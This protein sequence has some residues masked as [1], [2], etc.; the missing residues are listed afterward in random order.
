MLFE[1]SGDLLQRHPT[2]VVG[3]VFVQNAT[4]P[5]PENVGKLQ[6][7]LQEEVQTVPWKLGG[8]GL[9]GHSAI[10]RWEQ[11]FE[12][13]G[14]NPRTYVPS[15]AALAQRCL[16][17][18]YIRSIN[19]AADIANLIS[20][21]HLVPVGAHDVDRLPGDITVRL[22]REG[23]AFTASTADEKELP[24]GEPVYATGDDIRTRRWVWRQ[25]ETAM[26][27]PES[28]TIVFPV[29]GFMDATADRVE[30]ATRELALLAKAT[31]GGDVS[32]GYV[33]ADKPSLSGDDVSL[34]QVDD[35]EAA[36]APLLS[37]D[38]PDES[39]ETY[40]SPPADE[41]LAGWSL[42]DLLRRG[43]LDS[44]IVEEE[45]QEALDS[46]RRLTIYEGFDP[47]STSLHIGHYLSLRVLRWFQLQGHRVIMLFGDFTARIGD[48]T[49]QSAER[50]QLTQDQVVAN[51]Q[52][53]RN[54]ISRVL[55]LGGDNPIEIKWN[56]EWLDSLTLRDMIE[57][58]AN[59]TVQQLIERDMFQERLSQQR[60]LH[61]HET[62]YPLL[63]GYDSVAMSVD[64]ELGGR[65]QMFNM[66][67]G[68]DLV[69]NYNGKTKHVLM[70]P[71][72]PGLD[73]R[74]M[75]KSY[76]NTVDLTENPVDMFFKL[77]QVSDELLP[78][79]MSVLTD[80][81]DDEIDGVRLRLST[82][83]NLQNARERFAW[84]VTERLHGTD[85]AQRA[86]KEFT[87][88]V[89]EGSMRQ[90]VEEVFLKPRAEPLT[91]LDVAVATGLATSRS[92]ARRLIQQGGLEINDQRHTE[93]TLQLSPEDVEGAIIK[94]GK[95]GFVRMKVERA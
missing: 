6:R 38:S 3:V 89:D 19:P 48:P 75:S 41:A 7:T 84:A 66:M 22:S 10:T 32:Y 76:G 26:T 27:M 79:F 70:T 49:G 85:E 61:L 73:G 92:D 31:L 53:W 34:T 59:V 24:I 95:R 9:H 62:L 80:T 90:D 25:A 60:P 65:D 72:I 83:S 29:D 55:D 67:V 63:Q 81:P 64:A 82:E 46:G 2:Y 93:P 52:T 8:A 44:V 68:R 21:R 33:N 4:K 13:E 11:A 5:S 30:A 78:M 58:A 57:I 1:I 86:Q 39:A 15:V 69:R 14:I 50:L 36:T 71:L 16:R 28:R 54:Q 51:A 47:T 94:M 87:R 35:I 17:G 40:P 12:A 20:M 43:I 42:S 74:K 37:L 88:V 77:T 56:G 18:D 23:D 45:L 91:I